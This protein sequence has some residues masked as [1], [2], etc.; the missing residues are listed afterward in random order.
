[1]PVLWKQNQVEEG[2]YAV[3]DFTIKFFFRVLTNI[4]DST[5]AIFDPFVTKLGRLFQIR[6]DYMNLTSEEVHAPPP[7]SLSPQ[8]EAT[9]SNCILV[10]Q[11]KRLL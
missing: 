11:S 7:N 8:G 2:L 4:L 9:P 6:D 5:N 3:L 10:R 1:M